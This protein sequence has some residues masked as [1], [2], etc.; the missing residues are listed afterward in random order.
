MRVLINMLGLALAV[1]ACGAQVLSHGKAAG[2]DGST[3]GQ[4]Q[5]AGAA[6]SDLMD[7][8][9]GAGLT[10]DTTIIPGRLAVRAVHVSCSLP[11]VPH[12]IPICS[13]AGF[14]GSEWN[15]R[16]AAAKSLYRVLDRYASGVG[17]TRRGGVK[18]AVVADGLLCSRSLSVANEV[19]CSFYSGM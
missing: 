5:I 12:S 8:L 15:A 16:G 19:S 13:V 1:S 14:D 10:A 17:T 11:G 3:S 7:G 6:A 4:V 2:V 9:L 18:D